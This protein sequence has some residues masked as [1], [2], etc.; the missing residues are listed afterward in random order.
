MC[1][2]REQDFR[3]KEEELGELELRHANL[4]EEKAM[5]LVDAQSTR[6]E[7]VSLSLGW[8]TQR[9]ALRQD[10]ASINASIER[11]RGLAIEADE[12]CRQ[13]EQDQAGAMDSL[14][15]QSLLGLA[16]DELWGLR[17]DLEQADLRAVNKAIAMRGERV[18]TTEL[19]R[20]SNAAM[21]AV[22][23][24]ADAMVGEYFGAGGSSW[25][26]GGNLSNYLLVSVA[27]E[28]LIENTRLSKEANR[29]HL[30]LL[31]AT[32]AKARRMEEEFVGGEDD[33]R[34]FEVISPYGVAW[35]RTPQF[36]DRVGSEAVE[37]GEVIRATQ[38]VTGGNG[39]MFAY[40]P[41]SDDGD[42]YGWLPITTQEGIVV[43]RPAGEGD[44]TPRHRSRSRSSGLASSPLVRGAPGS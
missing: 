20:R 21:D 13:G 28:Q 18:S 35:R 5:V 31:K 34:L 26:G 38:V 3:R 37:R 22:L 14:E 12:T 16:L 6:E 43:L 27:L 4:V 7:A 15:E 29:R 33:L 36:E 8:S 17:R 42:E 24:K 1:A 41:A 19:M 25:G 23:Q 39:I 10:L 32:E 9:D 44:T 40:V 11:E 2:R 30:E